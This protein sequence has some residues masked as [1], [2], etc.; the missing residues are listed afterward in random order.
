MTKHT[1]PVLLVFTIL[2]IFS[3]Y[4]DDSSQPS[5]PRLPF[6]DFSEFFD[7]NN[8]VGD[9]LVFNSEEFSSL[10]TPKGM[11]I[12]IPENAFSVGGNVSMVIKEATTKSDFI[13]LNKPTIDGNTWLEASH[14]ISID[15]LTNS[16][17]ANIDNPLNI[18]M[19]LP[20]GVS[21]EDMDFYY[22]Q[23]GWN[24]DSDI[25][26]EAV[27][28]SISFATKKANWQMG[29]K[30]Y[31][32]SGTAQVNITTGGYGTIPHDMRAFAVL[33]ESNVVIPLEYNVSEVTASGKVPTGVDFHIVL[34]IMD[35][36]LL[37]A[38]TEMF[39]IS[40]DTDLAVPVRVM[41]LDEAIMTIKEID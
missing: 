13:F 17:Q 28:N 1:L 41:S 32:H 10:T 38:G 25:N 26:V 29:A 37:S 15:P 16:G 21:G 31:D 11:T 22:F 23:N 2:S 27:N 6:E 24:K 33:E 34:M 36:F 9:T 8:T 18:Q 7:A 40:G 4:T 20:S 5:L 39:S 19:N 12:E 35:H 30:E 14:S 3:C